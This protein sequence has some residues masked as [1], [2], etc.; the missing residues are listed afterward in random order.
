MTILALDSCSVSAS[1]GVV[2]DGDLLAQSFQNVGLTHSETLLPMLESLLLNSKLT[3]QSLDLVAVSNGPGSFT[4]L[5]IG[6]SAALGFALS[7][8]LPCVGVSS[9]EAAARSAVHT[10]GLICACMDARRD[11]VYNAMFFSENGRLTRLCEDRAVALEEVLA[12]IG[13]RRAVFVG[14]GARMCYNEP[15]HF[16]QYPTAYGVAGCVIAGHTRK[17]DELCYLRLPQAERERLERERNK[18]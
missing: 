16:L 1:V 11:Q 13:D 10:E 15:G 6:V 2:R 4:G 14:D 18:P 9:L 3:P 8:S 5:R 17:A 12:E 7:L